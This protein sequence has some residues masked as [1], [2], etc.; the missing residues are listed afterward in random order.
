MPE[1]KASVQTLLDAE[2]LSHTRTTLLS[3]PDVVD[4]G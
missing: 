1:L 2:T 4:L 3:P